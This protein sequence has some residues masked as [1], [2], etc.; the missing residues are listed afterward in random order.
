MGKR[1]DEEDMINLKCTIGCELQ[2]DDSCELCPENEVPV[3]QKR[4]SGICPICGEF[5]EIYDNGTCVNCIIEDDLEFN[6][7][8]YW[9]L[10]YPNEDISGK[11]SRGFRSGKLD[12]R[13]W[14]EI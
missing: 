4:E 14:L 11:I 1:G 10:N 5:E 7:G 6:T 2:L 9:E 13:S 12:Q 8:G 3:N